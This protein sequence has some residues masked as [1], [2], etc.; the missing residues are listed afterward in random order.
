MTASRSPSARSCSSV[1]RAPLGLFWDCCRGRVR[2]GLARAYHIGEPGSPEY[3]LGEDLRTV[4]RDG[5]W[6]F[7]E[8]EVAELAAVVGTRQKPADK[9]AIQG[10]L[11]ELLTK[12]DRGVGLAGWDELGAASRFNLALFRAASE[13]EHLTVNPARVRASTHI[14]SKALDSEGVKRVGGPEHKAVQRLVADL[15]SSSRPPD[16]VE[17]ARAAV[18]AGSAARD[19]SGLPAPAEGTDGPVA[20]KLLD[21]SPPSVSDLGFWWRKATETYIKN[22]G[23]LRTLT[24][25]AGAE[26]WSDVGPPLHR[27]LLT[28]VVAERLKKLPRHQ[29]MPPMPSDED[30]AKVMA[31]MPPTFLGSILR[32][33]SSPQ[34]SFTSR[35]TEIT[36]HDGLQHATTEDR[37]R[38][39]LVARAIAHLA[40]TLAAGGGDARVFTAHFDDDIA[41]AED[42]LKNYY[43]QEFAEVGFQDMLDR[44][45]PSTASGVVPLLRVHSRL[46]DGTTQSIVLGEADFIADEPVAADHGDAHVSRMGRLV[47]DL[48][49]RPTL[50]VGTSILDPGVIAALALTRHAGQPRY[51]V[52]LLPPDVGDDPVVRTWTAWLLGRRYLH[53]GVTPVLADFPSQVPQ[54][55]REI[56]LRARPQG[57]KPTRA[58]GDRFDHWW[59]LWCGIFGY[60]VDGEPVGVPERK[61]HQVWVDRLKFVRAY[62]QDGELGEPAADGERITI[63]VWLQNRK[64]RE[65]FHWATIGGPGGRKKARDVLRLSHSSSTSQLAPDEQAA[66]GAFKAGELVSTEIPKP[67]NGWVVATN[68]VL[69]G[70]TWGRL[71][72]GVVTIESND[73]DGALT[74]IVSQV[75]QLSRLA[76][77]VDENLRNLLLDKD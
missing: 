10:K 13:T 40:F 38:G 57:T 39:G 34:T 45:P 18:P 58:Y 50:F 72:V 14:R 48:K 46:N 30:A 69:R 1:P 76:E 62:I 32:E 9:L 53:L 21:S 22:L 12:A 26:G 35:S 5:F 11:E 63:N 73:P 31:M 54:F 61:T 25:Y 42:N 49:E 37:Q 74:S 24:I 64:R 7:V 4:I 51:A 16:G 29:H 15:L 33:I 75:G 44:L 2:S 60:G 59:T 77:A 23:D 41:L 56:A 6:H 17:T 36:L 27:D 66:L 70:E 47:Q 67:R 55:L 71:T 19:R 20:R 43:E 3:L 28:S 52:L 8:A 68:L 65:L